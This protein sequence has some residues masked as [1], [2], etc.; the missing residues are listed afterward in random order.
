MNH[1]NNFGQQTGRSG[2]GRGTRGGA[3]GTGSDRGGRDR[4]GNSGG[5]NMDDTIEEL[6]IKTDN[7]MCIA[8]QGCCHGELDAIYDRIHRHEEST[9]GKVD[10]LLCCGDFQSLRSTADYHSL[11]VPPKYRA[12]GSFYKYYSGEK[13]APVLTIFIGGNHEASQPLQELY[14]GG[15]VAPKIYYLGAAGVV[16]VGG[17]RI[18]GISGIYKSHDF[19]QG[20]YERPPY[21]KSTMRSIYHVRNM[22][23]YRMKSLSQGP[24]IM[25]SHDWPQGIEQHGNIQE[26]LR[27]KPFF[28]EEVER[29]DLGSPCNRELLDVLKPKW[30]FSAHLHVKFTA[31]VNHK[32]QQRKTAD[33]SVASLVP[34]QVQPV[35]KPVLPIGDVVQEQTEAMALET[36]QF[37]AIESTDNC[38]GDD[39]TEQM[40][41]FLS[42]DKCLPRR[43]FLSILHIPSTKPKDVIEYDAEWLAILKK[44]HHLTV[45]D[46]KRVYVPHELVRITGEELESIHINFPSLAIPNNFC[47]T[48][49]PHDPRDRFLPPLPIM[50]NPQCDDFLG[51]LGLRHLVTVPYQIHE[52]LVDGNEI[53]LDDDDDEIDA[54]ARAEFEVDNNEIDLEEDEISLGGDVADTASNSKLE[55]NTLKKPRLDHD[56]GTEVC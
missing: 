14:Y 3:R 1:R 42:L 32:P 9:A 54:S 51:L 46:R 29:N 16:N 44:T 49:P 19:T 31:A 56:D 28:R 5:P 2:R 12:I 24:D 15:W 43:Q 34:S 30:W 20:R 53:K 18:G 45:T 37:H 8:I 17:I 13:E 38:H 25:M 4:F 22:D 40:T 27:K 6:G 39:L 11:A 10:L 7:S 36:T 55:E 23:V 50:G 52:V 21:D 41:R 26:L 48:V 33:S 35:S 47:I